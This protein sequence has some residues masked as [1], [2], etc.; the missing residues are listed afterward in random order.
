MEWSKLKTF[1]TEKL[2]G[3]S[4]KLELGR[5]GV[6]SRDQCQKGKGLGTLREH[7]DPTATPCGA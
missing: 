6:Y 2:G 7:W 1:F 5:G 3:T 4:E